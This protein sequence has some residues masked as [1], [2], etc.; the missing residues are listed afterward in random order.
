MEIREHN[1]LLVL[2]K[3]EAN[4]SATQEEL[5]ELEALEFKLIDQF[6]GR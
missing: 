4:K 1:R 2:T 6:N 3:K 5:K